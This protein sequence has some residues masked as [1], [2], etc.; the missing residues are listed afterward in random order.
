MT[1]MDID[2]DQLTVVC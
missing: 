2:A 1:E